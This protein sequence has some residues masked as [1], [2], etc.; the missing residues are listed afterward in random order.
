MDIR[1][2]IVMLTIIEPTAQP[3]RE[4]IGYILNTGVKKKMAEMFMSGYTHISI[5]EKLKNRMGSPYALKSIESN[6]KI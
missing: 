3:M 4:V 5:M 1:I 2:E 6:L